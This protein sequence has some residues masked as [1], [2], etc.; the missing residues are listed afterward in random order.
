MDVEKTVRLNTLAKE[1]VK[2]GLAPSSEDASKMAQQIMKDEIIEEPK[3]KDAI[4]YYEKYDILIERTAR[5]IN[6]EI[7]ALKEKIKS[8]ASELDFIRQDVKKLK[9]EK[10][11]KEV[12]TEKQE[13]LKE[14][15]QEN[16]S[17]TG[18]YKPE[19]VAVDKIFYFGKK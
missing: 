15:K 11:K 13:T 3:A 8:L 17:K 2:K 6:H 4:N 12:K 1:L 5:K 19:D 14:K 9:S 18:D 7:D 16:S 10:I